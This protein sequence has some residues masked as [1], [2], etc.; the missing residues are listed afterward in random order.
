MT[1]IFTTHFKDTIN[2]TT[3]LSDNMDAS[4]KEKHYIE[5]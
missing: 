4:W 5:Q 3:M 1:D 2:T